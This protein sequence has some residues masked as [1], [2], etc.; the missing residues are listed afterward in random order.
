MRRFREGADESQCIPRVTTSID[1]YTDELTDIVDGD[2]AEHA[3]LGKE[4]WPFSSSALAVCRGSYRNDK[5][6][7]RPSKERYMAKDL[8]AV[9][10]TG[11]E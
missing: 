10:Q 4:T 3:A 5:S 11:V 7:P 1:L 2:E 8:A 9:Q 6:K